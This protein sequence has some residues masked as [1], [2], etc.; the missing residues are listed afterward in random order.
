MS[1]HTD[2][3]SDIY[4]ALKDSR[5]CLAQARDAVTDTTA[6]ERIR[7]AMSDR[8]EQIGKID[9]HVSDAALEGEVGGLVAALQRQGRRL[10]DF[11]NEDDQTA[12]AEIVSREQ[13]LLK[14]LKKAIDIEE[15]SAFAHNFATETAEPVENLIEFFQKA[16]GRQIG[17]RTGIA[18]S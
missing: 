1:T 14:T 7:S 3:L 6:S 11:S 9:Q 12:F 15:P 13:T 4:S 8:E 16:T 2:I 10:D 5:R 17:V 18:G